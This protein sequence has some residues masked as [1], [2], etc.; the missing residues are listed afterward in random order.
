MRAKQS[1]QNHVSIASTATQDHISVTAHVMAAPTISMPPPPT[2]HARQSNSPLQPQLQSQLTPEEVEHQLRMMHLTQ[3]QHHQ[4]QRQEQQHQQPLYQ[5]VPQQRQHYLRTPEQDQHH[6]FQQPQIQ[7]SF[8]STPEPQFVIQPPP[9]QMAQ[10]YMTQQQQNQLHMQQQLL[11][12]LSQAG[13]MPDQ[14][15]LL[16]PV[17]REAIMNEAMRKIVAAERLDQ[18]NRRRLLKMER[19][20]KP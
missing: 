1:Q 8:S 6:V 17:Q 13:V 5:S 11:V 20:V 16:D 7:R 9:P 10:G 12:Q 4:A 19:M 14:I 15:H 18:R 2:Q 3:L